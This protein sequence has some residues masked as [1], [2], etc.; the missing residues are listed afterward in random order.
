MKEID[1]KIGKKNTF[2]KYT[3]KIHVGKNTFLI[4]DKIGFEECKW[5]RSKERLERL[6]KSFQWQISS[7]IA[8]FWRKR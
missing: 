6:S 8:R 1:G 7:Q 2:K 5:K 3:W 4:N